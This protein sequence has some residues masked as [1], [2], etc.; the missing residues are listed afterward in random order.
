MPR[1]VTL[2]SALAGGL[3]AAA[4]VSSS[5][6]A[7][8]GSS[9]CG[10]GWYVFKENSLVSSSLRSTTNGTSSLTVATGMTLGTSNC[11]KHKFVM[12][13]KDSLE[14]LA[15]SYGEI[16][17]QAAMGHGEHLSALAETM[18]CRTDR[19]WQFDAA[20]RADFDRAFSATTA[21]PAQALEAIL[22]VLLQ[23]GMQSQC[24]AFAA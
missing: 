13:E 24:A 14:L 10:P 23:H 22:E 3:L 19:Q 5:A 8:D 20:L 16:R 15:V 21:Q 2:F 17:M 9:G 7:M 12:R 1:F 4:L 6:L 11:A 18:G